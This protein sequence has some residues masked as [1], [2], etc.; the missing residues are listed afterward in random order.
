MVA[1]IRRV[2]PGGAPGVRE[3]AA[4]DRLDGAAQPRR[5]GPLFPELTL[6]PADHAW[7]AAA[8]VRTG[9]ARLGILHQEATVESLEARP[10]TSFRFLVTGRFFAS[11][12]RFRLEPRAGGTRV[13][14]DA[15]LQP[16]SRFADWMIRLRRGSLA[17]RVEIHLRA[18]KEI[19]EA[20]WTDDADTQRG[21]RPA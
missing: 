11:E 6:G 3:G 2:S 18:L 7:P 15:V 13:V 19:A 9:R 4:T 10:L 21:S 14:H 8:A 20:Q 1:R 12:W 17:E 16:G 5:H